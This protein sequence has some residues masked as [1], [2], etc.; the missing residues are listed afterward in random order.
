VCDDFIQNGRVYT[1][2]VDIDERSLLSQSR[3]LDQQFETV[4]VFFNGVAFFLRFS[5]LTIDDPSSSTS[6]NESRS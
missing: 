2:L 1:S 4:V 6:L 5:S 3:P